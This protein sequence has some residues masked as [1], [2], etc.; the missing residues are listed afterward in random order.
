MRNESPVRYAGAPDTVD[1]VGT[2]LLRI[3]ANGVQ[4]YVA[5]LGLAHVLLRPFEQDL[6]CAIRESRIKNNY[7]SQ[8]PRHTDFDKAHRAEKI[9]VVVF[10][11]GAGTLNE[12][13]RGTLRA[14]TGWLRTSFR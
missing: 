2:V 13:L 8:T 12:P 11:P 4:E 5:G 14:E 7:D 6:S 1:P 10:F 3:H 9:R